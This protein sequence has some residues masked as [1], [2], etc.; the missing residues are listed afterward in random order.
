MS[1]ECPNRLPR[2]LTPVTLHHHQTSWRCEALIDSGADLNLISSGVAQQ[3]GVTCTLIETPLRARAING[4]PLFRITRKTE[5]MRLCIE[6]HQEEIC[7]HIYDSDASGCVL[8]L[9]WLLKNNPTIDWGSGRVV[10]WRGQDVG[11]APTVIS[12]PEPDMK[13]VPD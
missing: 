7:F 4:N 10:E 13:G 3:L 11:C 1:P 5:S 8:G 2:K 6:E 9:P 12:T